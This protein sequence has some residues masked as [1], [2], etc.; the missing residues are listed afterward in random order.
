MCLYEIFDGNI[1]C[2]MNELEIFTPNRYQITMFDGTHK[3]RVKANSVI[4]VLYSPDENFI[5]F[6]YGEGCPACDFFPSPLD[7]L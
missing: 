7:K 3:L 2:P 1:S 4:D 6:S 5:N